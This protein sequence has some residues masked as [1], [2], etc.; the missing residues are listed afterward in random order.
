MRRNFLRAVRRL[1][2]KRRDRTVREAKSNNLSQIEICQCHKFTGKPQHY[3]P[4]KG[5]CLLA[6]IGYTGPTAKTEQIHNIELDEDTLGR[7]DFL[8]CLFGTGKIE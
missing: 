8:A 3:S 7:I 4:Q 6:H 5:W 2:F 1:R